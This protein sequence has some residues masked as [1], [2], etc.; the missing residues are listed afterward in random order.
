MQRLETSEE[1]IVECISDLYL[2]PPNM[3]IKWSEI[4]NQTCQVRLA[5]PGQHLASLITGIKGSG[6]AAR[7]DDLSD[8]SEVKSCSRAD[9]LSEC[10]TCGAKVLVWQ[11][12]C[13]IC[14][15]SDI[16]IKTYSHWIFAIKSEEE[17]DLLLNRIPRV[18]LI[19]FDKESNEADIIRLRAWIIHPSNEYVQNFFNNYFYENFLKKA[20]AAPCNLHPLKYDFFMMGPELIFHADMEIESRDVKILHW[21]IESPIVEKMPISLLTSKE[22]NE[23]FSKEISEGH[24]KDDLIRMHQT[25]PDHLFPMLTMR[26]KKIKTSKTQYQRR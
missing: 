1:L 2:T 20:N 18:L 9:Q 11:K 25:V 6:T 17:L 3:I 13:E 10:K 8:G 14:G 15:S 24:T 19:L 7:G 16:N 22:I 23:I 4:T 5:Y 26:K 21:N 12:E